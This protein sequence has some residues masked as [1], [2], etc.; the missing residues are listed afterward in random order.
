MKKFKQFLTESYYSEFDSKD[1][2]KYNSKMHGMYG[3]SPSEEMPPTTQR[4][5]QARA[6]GG[7]QQRDAAEQARI[8]ERAKRFPDLGPG[9]HS[10]EEHRAAVDAGADTDTMDYHH[11]TPDTIHLATPH[12]IQNAHQS[13]SINVDSDRENPDPKDVERLE[14]LEKHL[15]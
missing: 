2:K 6:S 5:P 14:F 4:S 10:H 8:A 13:L 3:K 11:M 7:T 12:E 9:Y 1:S 15:K